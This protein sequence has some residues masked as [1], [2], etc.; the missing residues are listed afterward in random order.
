MGSMGVSIH[1]GKAIW[2]EHHTCRLSETQKQEIKQIWNIV[3]R[4]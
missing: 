2:T 3:G 4:K 1:S